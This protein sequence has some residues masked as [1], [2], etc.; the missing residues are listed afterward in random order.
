MEKNNNLNFPQVRPD[1]KITTEIMEQAKK[2]IDVAKMMGKVKPH[3]EAFK[4]YPAQNEIHKGKENYY[5]N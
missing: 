4:K 5:F 1:E 3:T 2:V